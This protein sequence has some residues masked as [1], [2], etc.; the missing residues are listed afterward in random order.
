MDKLAERV[1]FMCRGRIVASGSL[2]EIRDL[3]DDHPFKIR[4]SADH[5][6]ELAIRLM[7]VGSVQAVQLDDEG[8]LLVQVRRPKEFFPAFA[9]MVAEA[10]L[11]VDRMR[12][13]DASTEAVFDYLMQSA[14]HP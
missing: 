1:L 6:R 3:L 4:V 14:M 12:V 2:Q 11:E 7:R 9:S 8:D 5:P 13:L 10:G